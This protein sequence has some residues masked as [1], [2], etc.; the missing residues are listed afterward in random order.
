[1][2]TSLDLINAIK[3][4]NSRTAQSVFEQLVQLA[5]QMKLMDF[6]ATLLRTCLVP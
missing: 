2:T 1:M 3:D 5:W 6:A 4:G